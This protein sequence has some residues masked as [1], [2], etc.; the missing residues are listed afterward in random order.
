MANG[1][2]RQ[3]PSSQAVAWELGEISKNPRLAIS[4]AEFYN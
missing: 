4:N 2:P 1:V 3:S